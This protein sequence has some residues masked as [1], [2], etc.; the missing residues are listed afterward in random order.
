MTAEYKHTTD[1]MSV[2]PPQ[3]ILQVNVAGKN[4]VTTSEKG[5]KPQSEGLWELE[6]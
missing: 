4:K 6:F 3:I 1:Q 5:R 2:T